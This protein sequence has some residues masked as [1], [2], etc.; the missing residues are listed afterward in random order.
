MFE[1]VALRVWISDTALERT[2]SSCDLC[3]RVSMNPYAAPIHIISKAQ[4]TSISTSVNPF[5]LVSIQ[6]GYGR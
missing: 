2:A 6:V 4:A 3:Q 5:R 1:S